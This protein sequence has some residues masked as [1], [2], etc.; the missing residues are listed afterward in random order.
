MSKWIVRN[1]KIL[2]IGVD[3]GHSGVKMIQLAQS[4]DSLRVL[5]VG[6]AP[7][8]ASASMDDSQ[9]QRCAISAIRQLLAR[10]HFRGRSAVSALSAEELQI[11]SVRLAEAES[12]QM[13]K[14]LRKEAAGRFDLDVE[15]DAIDYL[16]AGSVRQDDE[17]KNEFIVLAAKAQTI[18]RHIALLEEAG[19][20][21]AGIDV[22]PCALFRSFER[23]MRREEDK[24][25]TLVFVDVGYR[26][27]TVAFGR[28]GE[29]CLA[30][31]MPFGI[32]RFDEE[33]ASK[34]EISV[35]DA[36]SVRLRMQRDESVEE[37]TRHLVTDAL[38]SAAEQLT[39]ELSLCLRYHTVTFRGK[40]VERALVA[41]GGAH[42]RVLL[43]VL[44]R[45]LSIAVELGE[46]LR[47]LDLESVGGAEACGHCAPDLALAVGL[48]LKGRVPS[49]VVHE[50]PEVLPE[51]ALEGERP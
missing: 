17:V 48:S 14:A 11:T 31:Q 12:P 40:R 36:E 27:T 35:A 30:K 44:Q 33:I 34:L 38:A 18:E 26:Y 20:Q 6:Q 37:Q 19:L 4:E 47:G 15:T 21:P 5:S 25:R 9:R 2:P 28:N 39:R 49:A 13:D 22:A 45:H 32:A 10:G 24:Q 3:I 51:P 41:G 46:P 23:A 42:E 8:P 16:L 29:I 50:G 1:Q 43:D 7:M